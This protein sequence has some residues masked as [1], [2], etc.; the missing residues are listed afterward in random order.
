VAVWWT[1]YCD[2]LRLRRGATPLD[3][4]RVYTHWPGSPCW[5]NIACCM[6]FKT[7]RLCGAAR[8]VL[9]GRQWKTFATTVAAA[10]RYIPFDAAQDAIVFYH[11]TLQ[12]SR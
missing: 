11:L 10:F 12:I 7:R 5:P 3:V 9:P 2:A 1:Q 6:L 8:N 4:R